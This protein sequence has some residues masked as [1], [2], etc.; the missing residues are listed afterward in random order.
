MF[1][2]LLGPQSYWE[3]FSPAVWFLMARVQ[4]L[5]QNLEPIHGP[6]IRTVK[7]AHQMRN[8]DSS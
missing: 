7:F 2:F 5:G 6:T 8:E 3:L 4:T 1:L